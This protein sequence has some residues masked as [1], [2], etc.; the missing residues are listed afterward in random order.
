MHHSCGEMPGDYSV[1]TW[2]HGN[3]EYWAVWELHSIFKEFKGII[4]NNVCPWCEEKLEV[5]Q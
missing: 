5:E 2:R 1:K 4:A 3:I